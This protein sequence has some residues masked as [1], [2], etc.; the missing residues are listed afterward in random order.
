MKYKV[1]IIITNSDKKFTSGPQRGNDG[2][3]S[4]LG[5]KYWE[6]HWKSDPPI[7]QHKSMKTEQIYKD[8]ERKSNTNIKYLEMSWL[9]GDHSKTDREI[10]AASD[11]ACQHSFNIIWGRDVLVRQ[12]VLLAFS[13]RKD[14]RRSGDWMKLCSVLSDE[15]FYPDTAA[16]STSDQSCRTM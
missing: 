5:A 2:F 10:L 3:R 6:F 1:Q 7:S 15:K 11:Y 13:K 12:D 4:P 16:G 9:I 8:I 14:K